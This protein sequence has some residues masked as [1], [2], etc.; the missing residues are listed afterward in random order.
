M[1][2]LSHKYTLFETT[3]PRTPSLMIPEIRLLTEHFSGRKWDRAAQEAFTEMLYEQDDAKGHGLKSGYKDLVA[4]DRINR[5]PKKFGFVR[6]HPVVSLTLAGQHYLEASNKGEILL[7]QLLKYQLPSPYHTPGAT[8]TKF[9]VKP[10]LELFRLIRHFGSLS[11]D[12]MMLFGLQLT[13]YR[14]FDTIV[15]KIDIFRKEKLSY[16]GK[17]KRFLAQVTDRVVSEVFAEEIAKG[18]IHTRESEES[19][20]DK[21]VSTKRKN[22]RDYADAIFR[23]LRETGLVNLSQSGHSVSIVTDKLREVDYFLE[24][25]DRN[26]CFEKRDC[27]EQYIAYLSNPDLPV[28][29]TDDKDELLDAIRREA[30]IL[31]T[32]AD[33]TVHEL[34]ELLF[35][36]REEHKDQLIREEISSLKQQRKYDEIVE[37]FQGIRSGRYYDN[38]LMFEWNVWRAMTM[39]DGGSIKANLVFDDFGRPM[40]TAAG[41]MADIVC[42]YGDFGLTVELT[43]SSGQRQFAMESE[44]VPRHLGRYKQSTGKQAYCLFIAPRINEATIAFF[45]GLHKTPIDFYGGETI[46]VP[47]ELKYFEKMLADAYRARY[48]PSPANVDRFFR[49]IC[50]SADKHDGQDGWRHWY[51][52]ITVYASDWL[53]SEY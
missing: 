4:R 31:E 36:I 30:G 35:K 47:L 40:S 53:S 44:P 14:L 16:G 32:D 6:L 11:F 34:K 29:L 42:D 9:W 10:Y 13:D 49:R 45:F 48:R 39:L 2:T 7:R 27:L 22:M 8:G 21:F 17:Y 33:S 19:S 1:A 52:D 5:S 15:A 26:P 3:S 25:I 50:A 23:H 41:N 28:L 37:M 18:R 51:A 38:S 24:T 20:L 43:L 12:E 46:I